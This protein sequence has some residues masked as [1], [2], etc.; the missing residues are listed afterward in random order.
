M[1]PQGDQGFR[2]AL[3][4]VRMAAHLLGFCFKLIFV[5]WPTF[6]L[7]ELASGLFA[8]PEDAASQ[9]YCRTDGLLLPVNEESGQRPNIAK[10]FHEGAV[11]SPA[12]VQAAVRRVIHFALAQEEASSQWQV[13]HGDCSAM[14]ISKGRLSH[15]GGNH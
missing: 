9:Q 1:P 4:S 8:S 6:I 5:T 15:G 14:S 3:D 7:R 11:S 2:Q 10:P 13:R 12:P